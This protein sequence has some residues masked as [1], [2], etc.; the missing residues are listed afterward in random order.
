MNHFIY[1]SKDFIPV[2]ESH[3]GH[4]HGHLE[5]TIQRRETRLPTGRERTKRHQGKGA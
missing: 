4:T 2:E 5:I 1:I 3:A